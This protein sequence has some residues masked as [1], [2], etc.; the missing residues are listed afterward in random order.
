[1]MSLIATILCWFDMHPG[2]Y[3][4]RT[5]VGDHGWCCWCSNCEDEWYEGR[6]E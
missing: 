1:M 5:P 3:I 2:A 4:E 6:P